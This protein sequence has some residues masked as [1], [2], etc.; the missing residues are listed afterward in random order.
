[1]ELL[2]CIK[3][4][5]ILMHAR[6]LSVVGGE[7]YVEYN[8][9]RGTMDGEELSPDILAHLEDDMEESVMKLLNEI[10]RRI[11]LG[12]TFETPVTFANTKDLP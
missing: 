12:E 6:C 11:R 4:V 7:D 3:G 8:F 10:T 5:K 9:L 2:L 1:M